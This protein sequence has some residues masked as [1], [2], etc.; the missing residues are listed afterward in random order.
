[1]ENNHGR[2]AKRIRAEND[3]GSYIIEPTEEGTGAF[4]KH[5]MHHLNFAAG[6]ASILGIKRH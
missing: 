4:E 2:Y 3:R 6:M 1:M 5:H